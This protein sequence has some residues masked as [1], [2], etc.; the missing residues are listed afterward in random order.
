[1]DLVITTENLPE[2]EIR[3]G[4]KGETVREKG[5]RGGKGREVGI[6]IRREAGT[7]T[8][9]GREAKTWSGTESVMVRRK[10][11]V[12][13]TA[14]TE[15]ATGIVVNGGKGQGIEMK[16]IFTE[17]VTLTGKIVWDLTFELELEDFHLH[18]IFSAMRCITLFL[19]SF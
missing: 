3:S 9:I 17:A 11:T 15:I 19:N 13:G 4:R 7:R 12:I 8:E 1:M 16:M 6:E 18:L 5:K 14:T 2:A 10:G